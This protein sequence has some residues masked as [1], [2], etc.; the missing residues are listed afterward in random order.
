MASR[1]VS[2]LEMR[3]AMNFPIRM[4]VRAYN[5]LNGLI[6]NPAAG[7]AW[8]T[9]DTPGQFPQPVAGLPQPINLP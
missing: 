8:A 6:N 9:T 4:Y 2:L 7:A 5:S 1:Y 3:A